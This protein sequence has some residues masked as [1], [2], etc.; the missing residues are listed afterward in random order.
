MS[1]YIFVKHHIT[2]YLRQKSMWQIFSKDK[3]SVL[4]AI[5]WSY[6]KEFTGLAVFVFLDSISACCVLQH[7]CIHPPVPVSFMLNKNICAST[8]RIINLKDLQIYYLIPNQV[9][10]TTLRNMQNVTKCN[11]WLVCFQKELKK[12]TFHKSKY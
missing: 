5:I 10:I 4:W 8:F 2:I 7:L 11:S 1:L 3:W 12:K 6:K 9:T